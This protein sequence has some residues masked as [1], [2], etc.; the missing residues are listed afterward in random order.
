MKDASL[1]CNL[2][3]DGD[4]SSAPASQIGYVPDPLRD[5][6]VYPHPGVPLCDTM[7]IL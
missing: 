3:R 2:S 7:K 1:I 5:W 4:M 6:Y